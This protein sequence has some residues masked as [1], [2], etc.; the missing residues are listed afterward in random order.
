MARA[1]VD[2]YYVPSTKISAGCSSSR[3]ISWMNAAA[4]A[5][6]MIRRSKDEDRFMIWRSPSRWPPSRVKQVDPGHRR[7]GGALIVHNASAGDQMVDGEH[8]GRLSRATVTSWFAAASRMN[9]GAQRRGSRTWSSWWV[10]TGPSP[11]SSSRWLVPRCP[12]SWSR[13]EQ[14]TTWPALFGSR[15]T[16]RCRC[17]SLPQYLVRP[18][19]V[20]SVPR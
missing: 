7:A 6:S 16:N 3:L 4:S 15:W 11:R 9:N 2:A 20:P 19:D 1:C 8:F 12:S 10:V 14:R 17:S 5:P 18:F 13:R